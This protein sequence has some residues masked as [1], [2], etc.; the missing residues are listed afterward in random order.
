V[1]GTWLGQG[2]ISCGNLNAIFDNTLV[3][4]IHTVLK[5]PPAKRAVMVALGIRADPA[6]GDPAFCG[7]FYQSDYITDPGATPSALTIKFS[8]SAADS[9]TLAYADPW[10]ILLHANSYTSDLNTANG[11]DCVAA[12]TNGG[13]MMY[14]VF[15]AS[16]AG[17]TADVIVEDAAIAGGPYATLVNTTVIDVGTAPIAGIVPLATT[18]TV[19]Q[20]IR[21]Q[22]AWGTAT[23]ITFALAFVR[24]KPR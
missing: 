4:G 11:I 13:Y 5:T 17:H 1:I 8:P 16:G 21:W 19:R 12:T 3:S 10:G 2:T 6:I 14:Q 7:Q 18:A 15:S 22:V 9:A 24:G 20:F 23:N